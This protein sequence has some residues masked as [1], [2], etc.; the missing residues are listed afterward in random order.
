[1]GTEFHFV[2]SKGKIHAVKLKDRQRRD[3]ARH[4]HDGETGAVKVAAYH[5][6]EFP[7][8]E[9]GYTVIHGGREVEKN[10]VV[11]LFTVPDRGKGVFYMEMDPGVSGTMK[12][13]SRSRPDSST[14]SREVTAGTRK[15]HE[16]GVIFTICKYAGVTRR[17]FSP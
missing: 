11:F 6:I 8:V 2:T 4:V 10:C 1:M 12:P 7:A 14:S 5:G 16:I 9:Q 3:P 17:R 13:C 15:F